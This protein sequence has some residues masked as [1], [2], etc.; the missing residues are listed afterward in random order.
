MRTR[1]TPIQSGAA[2]LLIGFLAGAAPASAHNSVAVVSG[3]DGTVIV[4]GQPCRVVTRDKRNGPNSN[5]T[6]N[7]TTIIAGPNGVSGTTTVSP[8]GSSSSVTVGS[9]SSSGG[10]HSSSAASS[11]CVIYRDAPGKR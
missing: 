11:D 3:S 10:T 5:V 8:G 9:G 1:A 4:N 2:V 7:S 6:G